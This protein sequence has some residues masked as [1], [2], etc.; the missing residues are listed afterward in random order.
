MPD[1]FPDNLDDQIAGDV[2]SRIERDHPTASPAFRR[3]LVRLY[4]AQ[5]LGTAPEPGD[6]TNAQLA[7]FLG[8]DPRR[9]SEDFQ[10]ASMKL[11]RAWHAWHSEPPTPDPHP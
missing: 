4:V 5:A 3:K 2:A 11:R 7:D 8:V 10:T 9:L 6:I 1:D